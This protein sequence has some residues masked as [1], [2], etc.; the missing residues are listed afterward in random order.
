MSAL[1]AV[2]GTVLRPVLRTISRSRLPQ[3]QGTQQ[4]AGFEGQAEVFRDRWGIPHIYASNLKDLLRA[5]GYVH[6]QDRLWQME[7]NRRV[8]RGTLAELFGETALDTDRLI[9][10]LGFNRLGAADLACLDPEILAEVEAYAQGV[11]A[12][13]EQAGKKLPVEYMLVGHQPQPWTALDSMCFARVMIWQLSHAWTGEITRARIIEEVGDEHAADLEIKFPDRHPVILPQGIEFNRLMPDGML[14]AARG[15]FLQKSLNSGGGSNAWSIAARHSESGHAVH[16]NDMHLELSAPGLWYLVHL[17]AGDNS[18]L[19]HCIGASL[20]GVPYILV[21]HNSRI[22]WGMTLAFTD[23]E[24]LFVEKLDPENCRRYQYGNDWLEVQ[25]IPETIVVK[26]SPTPHIEEVL[27]THHGPLLSKPSSVEEPN[28]L[29]DACLGATYRD[30]AL[31]VQSMALQPCPA[32]QGFRQ[33]NYAQ[34]WDDFVSAMKLIEAP[35]LNVGYADVD[36]NIGFWCTGSVPIRA[37]GQ[38]LVPAP[39]WTGEY[40][41]IGTVPF[42][43]MPHALNPQQGYV[44]CCNHRIVDDDYPHFLGT[45][46][47]NGYRA[48]RIV[49]VFETA[50]RDKGK[51]SLA[52]QSALHTDFR[53]LSGEQFVRHIDALQSADVDVRLAQAILRSWNCRMSPDSGGASVFKVAMCHL[54]HAVVGS[55]LDNDLTLNYMGRGPHPLLLATS[56]FDGHSTVAML[57]LLDDPESWWL[58]QAGGRDIVL[59]QALKDAIVYLRERF[60]PD[61]RHWSWGKLHQLVFPH[62]MAVQPPMDQVFNIGPFP[63][64]GDGDTVCQ[65]AYQA[66][67]PYM[68]NAWAPS[69]RQIVDMGDL[70]GALYSTP[71]GQSGQLGSQHYDDIAQPWLAGEYCQP[72][73][74]RLEVESNCKAKLIL[75]PAQK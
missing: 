72:P 69:F 27:I 18:E 46:W 26:G 50:L 45:V 63:V 29:D 11:N 41:W 70:E 4:I 28:A 51:I 35:Q 64:G 58:K 7:V 8:G 1:N 3:V 17:N 49:D 2:L 60:G 36:D 12:F 32:I 56:E 47:M 66:A 30:R 9:R 55:L 6:A 20:P 21:G 48:R 25:S 37:K 33:L 15:P 53:S 23:C 14:E 19:L 62:S 67:D 74:N 5:Q 34:G 16:C 24:D 68:V 40:E 75:T 44:V 10:T 43:E 13:I 61:T 59:A 57:A 71:P 65:T 54:V 38:G 52:D 42:Q 39:G 22:A 73:W 31:A